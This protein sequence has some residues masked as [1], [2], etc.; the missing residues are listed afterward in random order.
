MHPFYNTFLIIIMLRS[1]LR[2]WANLLLTTVIFLPFLG[3][4]MASKEEAI[5]LNIIEQSDALIPYMTASQRI[6]FLNLEAEIEDAQSNR[7]SGHYLAETKPSTFDPNR[8]IKEVV[9]RGKLMIESANLSIRTNQKSLV[10]LLTTVDAQKAAKE[11]I[12]EARFDYILESSTFEEAMA[13]RCQQ[14]LQR[15]WQ[16]DYETLFFDGVFTQDSEG[17]HRT[18]AKLRNDFYNTLTKID[19]NAFSVTI[20]VDFKLKS[21]KLSQSSQIFS[22]KNEAIFEKDKKALLAIELIRPEGSSSGLLSLR[23]IDLDT[24]LIAVQQIVKV[25]DLA[26]AL[27]IEDEMLEDRLLTRITLRDHTNTLETLTRLVDAYIYEIEPTAP[28]NEVA[29][30]LTNTLLNQTNLQISDRD[31]VFRAYG[32]SLT[33]SDTWEGHANARLIIARG[34]EINSYQLSAQSNGSD[35]TLPCGE[36]TLGRMPAEQIAEVK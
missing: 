36:L 35:R 34:S 20:P 30:I 27:S 12:D 3:S 23:A 26:A 32:D 14:L 31:F 21:S 10:A 1:R 4:A 29:E 17:T 25:D 16:L 22:Y 8:D 5:D 7:R 18:D 15:C 11:T 13:T 9:K 28:T 24:Q 6:Q 33:M 2:S 19:S